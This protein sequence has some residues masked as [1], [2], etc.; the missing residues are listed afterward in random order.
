MIKVF[1]YGTLKKGYRNHRLLEGSNYIGEG[2]I[3]GYDLYDLGSFPGIIRG[4][5]EV[6]GEIYEIDQ[7]TLKRVDMLESEG[8]LYSRVPV[9]VSQNGKMV[10]AATY[11]FNRS[12][13]N[14]HRIEKEWRNN[15]D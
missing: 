6:V 14:A 13:N 4:K 7:E 1:V 15:Y 9:E 10:K 12:V 11:V 3:S 2:K 5:G 8:Q